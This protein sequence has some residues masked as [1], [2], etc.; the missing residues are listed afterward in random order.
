[1][2]E[3]SV[4]RAGSRVRITAR[5]IDAR[6]GYQRWS[7]KYDREAGDM[8]AVEDEISR[9]I[10]GALRVELADKTASGA[11]AEETADPQAHD[12]YLLGLHH[13]SQWTSAQ[14]LEIA[15]DYFAKAV[16]WDSGYARA[17]AG[18]GSAKV[19]LT[20]YADVPGP[21]LVPAGRAAVT[22]ALTLD[23]TLAPAHLAY[24]YLLKSYDWN[25]SAAE[26]EY[27]T[28]IALDPNLATA[29]QWLNELLTDQGRLA[30]ARVEL[31]KALALDPASPVM[32]LE[33]G[34]YYH[35]AGQLDSA[36]AAFRRA[37]ELSPR[38]PQ[39]YMEGAMV[40]LAADRYP[41][42]RD[43]MRQGA[44]VLGEPPA[45]FLTFLSGVERPATR[46]AA[47]R[48][49][50]QWAAA[51]RFPIVVIARF[52]ALLGESDRA[53]TLL[54]RAVEQRAPFTTYMGRWTELHRL[55][56]EPRFQAVLR[57]IG[58]PEPVAAAS[59]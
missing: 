3:G 33:A 42:A 41:E 54:E 5:L 8:F 19:L 15:V 9:A 11:G 21:E 23:S 43:L 18:V 59:R 37:T 16:A 32:R 38:F 58:L 50:D 4:Q 13:M 26:R 7:D 48:V 20:E 14:D 27:R 12:L 25:W 6:T 34:Q 17:W 56:G 2:L 40:A 39:P 1:V 49:V 36:A 30:E 45:Q 51:G 57:R 24:A 44:E 31:G 28:A 35:R 55:A 47:V 29:H 53:L 22:R 46:P 52:Y 10:A